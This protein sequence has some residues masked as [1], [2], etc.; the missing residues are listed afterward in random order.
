MPSV[1]TLNACIPSDARQVAAPFGVAMSAAVAIRYHPF[2]G[3]LSKANFASVEATVNVPANVGT[4]AKLAVAPAP[5][6]RSRSTGAAS[7]A[8]R[9]VPALTE[10]LET[11]SSKSSAGI[12]RAKNP[13][14]AIRAEAWPSK[15]R[16][17]I[18]LKPRFTL[19]RDIFSRTS[20]TTSSPM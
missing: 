15:T 3:V 10:P 9:T 6:V 5:M 14:A 13:S 16:I 8:I 11:H 4:A 18:T 7:P 19:S 20:A 17:G 12:I 1:T 2:S